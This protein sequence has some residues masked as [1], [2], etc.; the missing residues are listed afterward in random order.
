[1]SE[2]FSRVGRMQRPPQERVKVKGSQKDWM[3][4]NEVP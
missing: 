4:L 2:T 3:M 1:M